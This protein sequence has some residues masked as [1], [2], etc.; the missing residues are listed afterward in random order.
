MHHPD[1]VHRRES[2]KDVRPQRHHPLQRQRALT[3]DERAQIDA[4]HVLHD[5][6]RGAI[7][8]TPEVDDADDVAMID[9]R[10][11]RRLQIE[12]TMSLLVIGQQKLQRHVRFER[13]VARL[14]DGTHA[15]APEDRHELKL[16]RND[17]ADVAG[18]ERRVDF[19][20]VPPRFA[21]PGRAGKGRLLAHRPA[22]ALSILGAEL[23][24]SANS[25]DYAPMADANDRVYADRDTGMRFISARAMVDHYME[26]YGRK[27]GRPM[28]RID[29]S[30]RSEVRHGSV[31]VVVNVIE[32]H[33]VLVIHA[34]VGTVPATG[35]E[36]LYQEL[37]EASYLSTS[38]AAFAIDTTS[39]R[40]VVRAL[41]R[42][43]GLDYEELE[44]LIDTVGDVADEWD[45][46]F[47]SR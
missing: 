12:T 42:L 46:R 40:L 6:V 7:G 2:E 37:L 10:E 22:R 23:A 29:A 1:I 24:L 39:S 5:E 4:R 11:G 21:P 20:H 36:A 16:A 47:R 38:D 41:R 45:E 33:G 8:F 30:G 3:C 18:Q 28:P 34:P 13:R 43:S 44:D 14:E 35:R 31:V 9:P 15:P 17:A 19:A 32:D 27:V 25:W 26:R